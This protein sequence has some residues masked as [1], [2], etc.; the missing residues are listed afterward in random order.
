MIANK[1]M[2]QAGLVAIAEEP[3]QLYQVC[4]LR[5]VF[6]SYS[7]LSQQLTVAIVYHYKVALLQRLS[8]I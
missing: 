5:T 2:K 7:A 1:A 3:R 6:W 8:R 4:L